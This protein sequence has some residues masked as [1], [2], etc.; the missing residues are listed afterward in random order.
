MSLSTYLTPERVKILSGR[1]KQEVLDE[2][3]ALSHQC[4]PHVD[5]AVLR[6]AIA[7]RETL[8]STGIGQGLAVPHARLEGVVEPLVVVGVS[9]GGVTGYDSLD[10]EPVHVVLLIVAGKGQHEPYLR[11]LAA[12]VGALKDPALRRRVIECTTAEKACEALVGA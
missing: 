5:A 6:K 3:I 11:L 7:H 9:A 12:A 2:M 8:M 4:F 10:G 1:T